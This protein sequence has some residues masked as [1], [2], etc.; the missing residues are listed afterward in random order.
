MPYDLPAGY[1]LGIMVEL[2]CFRDEAFMR[3]GL[4]LA[5]RG[6]G[7]VEPN[8]MVGCVIVRGGRVVGEGYHR[9]FGGPHA[10]VHALRAAGPAARGA[11]CYVTLEPCCHHGKTPP[12]TEALIA[13][14]V[15]RVIVAM[16]D[17][18]PL[19]RGKGF[20]QLRACGIDVAVGLLEADAV[21]LN[22]P[23]LKLQRCGRP[24]VILKW[25][26]SLD[27]KIATR[28][29]DS[30]WISG[31]R[32]RAYA[33]RMRGRVDAV[34]VGIGTVMKDNPLLTCRYGRPGRIAARVVVD[35]HLQV[36]MSA[37]LVG[38]AH[39]YP[40]IIAGDRKLLSGKKAAGLRKAGL[41][42]VGLGRDRSGGLD[43]GALLDE[44][45]RRR[46]TNVMVEGGGRTLGAFYDA[47]LADEAVVFVTPVLM[48]G[49][50]AVSALGGLG[51]TKMRELRRPVDIKVSRSGSDY[52]YRL[53]LTDPLRY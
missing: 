21:R 7:R 14:G 48:G 29:G 17:P 4:A 16:R 39:R 22:G 5:A 2:F 52:V 25:A 46:M 32:S 36:P 23:Y 38:T 37:R 1:T 35:P 18:F 53:L 27:G 28:T 12:C 50:E 44:L 24:W 15:G 34:V 13:A 33:Q 3:R 26:Q 9:R 42:L 11:T 19:V 8:P 47:G 41:E 10:E 20:R 43:M 49:R 45:G 30:K 51:P 31:E 40:T 6:R